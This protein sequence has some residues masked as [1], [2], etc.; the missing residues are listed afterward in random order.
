MH[1]EEVFEKLVRNVAFSVFL[2]CF[3]FLPSFACVF[4]SCF[5]PIIVSGGLLQDLGLL[6]SLFQLRTSCHLVFYSTEIATHRTLSSGVNSRLIT[7]YVA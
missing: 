6:W 7:L 3:V 1:N 2:S 5:A 4:E